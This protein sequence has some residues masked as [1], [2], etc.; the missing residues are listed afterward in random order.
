MQTVWAAPRP[1]LHPSWEEWKQPSLSH[2]FTKKDLHY[3]PMSVWKTHPRTT[4][5]KQHQSSGKQKE[6]KRKLFIAKTSSFVVKYCLILSLRH[7]LSHSPYYFS[8]YYCL[9]SPIQ[10]VRT[11]TSQFPSW[12]NCLW[13]TNS[14]FTGVLTNRWGIDASHL[15]ISFPQETGCCHVCSATEH[16]HPPSRRQ[17]PSLM[18]GTLEGGKRNQGRSTRSH[19]HRLTL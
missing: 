5:P 9:I 6:V 17:G 2:Y 16:R 12:H 7:L 19:I 11:D 1:W 18:G 8:S 13:E 4:S 3:F 15:F 10:K 14:C